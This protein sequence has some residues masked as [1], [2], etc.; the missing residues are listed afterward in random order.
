MGLIGRNESVGTS[1]AVAKG[2]AGWTSNGSGISWGVY[3][4]TDST[5]VSSA[6]VRGRLD[7]PGAQGRAIWGEVEPATSGQYNGHAGYFVGP[8][9]VNCPSP[10]GCPG[11]TSNPSARWSAYIQGNLYVNGQIAG[12]SKPFLIDHPLVPENK[13]LVHAAVESQEWYKIPE[14]SP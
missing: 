7:T 3:G 11:S 9:Y 5:N 2:V 12:Q 13:Y 8:I 10:S 1:T 14:I 6:G 4:Q